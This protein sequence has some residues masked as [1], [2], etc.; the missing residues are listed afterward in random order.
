[1]ARRVL[2]AGRLDRLDRALELIY[3]HITVRVPSAAA[4]P[5]RYLINPYGLNYC[6]VTATNLVLIDVDGNKLDDSPYPVNA[7]GFVIHSA[8]H[9]ARPDAHCVIHTHTTA[10]MAI[11]CK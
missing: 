6:E 2:S 4:E 5:A 7:A 10:G 11:A 1:R 9:A 3:N 8:I